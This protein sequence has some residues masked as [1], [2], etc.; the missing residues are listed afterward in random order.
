M[1]SLKRSTKR[2]SGK[3]KTHFEYFVVSTLL[4]AK[5]CSTLHTIVGNLFFAALKKNAAKKNV[6][7]Y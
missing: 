3:N 7:I 1:K 4:M 6:Q 5:V 2:L